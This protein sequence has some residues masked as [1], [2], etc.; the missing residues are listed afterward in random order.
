MEQGGKTAK[1]E[2]RAK[3]RVARKGHEGKGSEAP[4]SDPRLAEAFAQHAAIAEILRCATM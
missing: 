1:S 4:D 2:A 3:Q